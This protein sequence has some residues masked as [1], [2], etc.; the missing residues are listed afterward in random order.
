MSEF[1]TTKILDGIAIVT[2][3]NPPVNAIDQNIRAGLKNAFESI[4][5]DSNLKAVILRCAGR[6]FMAGADIK[7]FDAPIAE[8]G[9][10]E[11]FET[12]ENSTKL[13]VAAMHGTALGAGLEAA[14]ALS[15]IHI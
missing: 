4:N 10:H 8:P 1:V 9:Y 13:V 11:V 2:V 3:D 14:L 15:L 7:E 6:T 12:I 5:A